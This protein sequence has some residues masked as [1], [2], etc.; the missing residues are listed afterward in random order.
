MKDEDPEDFY[1]Y[2][3]LQPSL[4]MLE[5]AHS[6]ALITSKPEPLAEDTG[7]QQHLE[8]KTTEKPFRF[9]GLTLIYGEV[10][11]EQ[12]DALEDVIMS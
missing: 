4:G 1:E 5:H 11:S 2:S 7:N 8:E 12:G 9:P 3:P 6:R 10:L